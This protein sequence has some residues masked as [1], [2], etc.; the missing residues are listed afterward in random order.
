MTGNTKACLPDK[1]VSKPSEEVVLCIFPS[2]AQIRILRQTLDVLPSDEEV[3]SCGWW[4]NAPVCK[5]PLPPIDW[6]GDEEIP[7]ELRRNSPTLEIWPDGMMAL[8][9]DP[10]G[11]E[12][13]E[14]V[15]DDDAGKIE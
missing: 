10:F 12:P 13:I 1:S 11:A 15:E 4:M 7:D 3:A 2:P 9:F 6:V 8:R 14:R 5:I